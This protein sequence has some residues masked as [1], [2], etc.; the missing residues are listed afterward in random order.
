[1]TLTLQKLNTSAIANDGQETAGYFARGIRVQVTVLHVLAVK[2]CMQ[3]A[4]KVLCSTADV[5]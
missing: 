2:V 5:C 3:A 1:M 4:N